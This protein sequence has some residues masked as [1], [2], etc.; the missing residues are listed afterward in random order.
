M[1]LHRVLSKFLGVRVG[2]KFQFK[3]NFYLLWGIPDLRILFSEASNHVDYVELDLTLSWRQEL[4][5]RPKHCYR[6]QRSGQHH[7]QVDFREKGF[8]MPSDQDIT[9]RQHLGGKISFLITMAPLIYLFYDYGNHFYL[10]QLEQFQ[11]VQIEA[12]SCPRV[13]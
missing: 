6:N 11:G 5:L 2:L 4:D 7:F 9:V 3:T 13:V 12:P 10:L 8:L 1:S